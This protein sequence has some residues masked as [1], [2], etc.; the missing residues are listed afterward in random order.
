MTISTTTTQAEYAGDGV[1]TEFSFAFAAREVQD[2]TVLVTNTTTGE[3][4]FNGTAVSAG[5]S[6]T[7][8]L[9]DDF[10]VSLTDPGGTVDFGVSEA[11][12]SGFRVTIRRSTG[13]TQDTDYTPGDPFPAESHEEALDKLT[14]IAQE[15]QRGISFSVRFPLGDD[16]TTHGELPLASERAGKVLTFDAQGNPSA[17]KDIP[18]AT[19]SNY[20]ET[21]LDDTDAATARGT[22]GL[23][24][25]ATQS[26]S[27]VNITG[28][29]ISGINDLA[30]DDGGTGASTP[31]GARANLGLAIGSDVQGFNANLNDIAG[32]TPNLDRF[33]VGNGSKWV[34]ENRSQARISLGL[35][36]LATSNQP[37]QPTLNAYKV[38]TSDTTWSR[39]TGTVRVLVEV[40]GAGGGGGGAAASNSNDRTAVG[41]GGGAGGYAIKEIDVSSINSAS[42]TVG[43]SGSGAAAGGNTGSA[44]GNS[45]WS[46]GTNTVTGNGGSGGDTG[47]P[48]DKIQL[49]GNSA[50]G[51]TASGGDVN[52]P[53]EGSVENPSFSGGISGTGPGGNS[54]YGSTPRQKATTG[55]RD[56]DNAKGFGSGGSGG[57]STN[58]AGSAAA[59]G[60][61][62]PGI[63]IVREFK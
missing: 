49:V 8:T 21:L 36:D 7:L 31:S 27:S 43:G 63:V 16:P 34:A 19:I 33:I 29:S 60:D 15:L 56:G 40:L 17:G 2:V 5:A 6:L 48:S 51:G 52:V 42:I 59:G 24:S 32:L 47:G 20:A 62:A 41:G 10:T 50:S 13:L 57:V 38:F 37:K 1:T 25:I 58:N 45:Q 23:G 22:L 3:L 9:N 18:A 46:D 26:A 4:D 54:V 28:G 30:V 53:G 12:A 14:L 39:E 55:S 35:G 11:P 61:G 44:G